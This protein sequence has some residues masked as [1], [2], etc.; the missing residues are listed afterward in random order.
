MCEVFSG[1]L[2]GLSKSLTA[3]IITFV[4][5]LLTR[6]IWLYTAVLM[7]HNLT[8]LF[9]IYPISWVVTAAIYFIYL[10]VKNGTECSI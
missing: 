2:K 4:G 8:V 6:I 5:I 9:M 10:A 3:F 1:T 7:T